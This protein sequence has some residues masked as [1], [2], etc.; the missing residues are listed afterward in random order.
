MGVGEKKPSNNNKQLPTQINSW[1]KKTNNLTTNKLIGWV[2][3]EKEWMQLS[4][5][6]SGDQQKRDII[7][8]LPPCL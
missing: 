7:E 2:E 6:I 1:T 3:H 4:M 8:K 5:A